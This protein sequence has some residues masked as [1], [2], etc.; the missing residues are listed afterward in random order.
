MAVPETDARPG[1][2]AVDRPDAQ[3]AAPISAE[4]SGQWPAAEPP[5]ERPRWTSLIGAFALTLIVGLF[6][7]V[8]ISSS[9]HE[10]QPTTGELR[11]RVAR[12][13]TQVRAAGQEREALSADNLRLEKRLAELQLLVGAEIDSEAIIE[14][15]TS[16]ERGRQQSADLVRELE[17]LV[18]KNASLQA[19]IAR[20]HAGSGA[21][22]TTAPVCREGTTEMLSAPVSQ[23]TECGQPGSLA[24]KGSAGG[25]IYWTVARGPD[26][27]V[28]TCR[29]LLDQSPSSL[30]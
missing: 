25:R 13:Q 26:T 24:Y 5:T 3:T 18:R 10:R 6:I 28:C 4:G 8:L 14:M 22:L 11:L 19:D 23:W 15:S 2:R 29:S 30:R 9:Y 1:A 12:L 17:V 21:V 20:L 16:L 7:G 27:W